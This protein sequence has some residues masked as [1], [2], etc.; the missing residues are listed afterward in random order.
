MWQKKALAEHAAAFLQLCPVD[1]AEPGVG[2]KLGKATTTL[3]N[4]RWRWQQQLMAAARVRT[5]HIRFN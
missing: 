5:Q 3:H 2:P 1:A 4:Q